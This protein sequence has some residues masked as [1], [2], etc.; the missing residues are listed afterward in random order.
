[1]TV[2]PLVAAMKTVR[3]WVIG[4]GNM[5]SFGFLYMEVGIVPTLVI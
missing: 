2:F 5:L 1:M 4:I 3:R